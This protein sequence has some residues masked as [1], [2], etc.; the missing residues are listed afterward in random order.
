MGN[1]R[2]ITELHRVLTGE[3]N[4]D[5][6]DLNEYLEEKGHSDQ[7]IEM[8]G[9]FLGGFSADEFAEILIKH[10]VELQNKL[11]VVKQKT[12]DEAV[13]RELNRQRNA[14]QRKYSELLTL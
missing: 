8:I 9:P 1:K 6:M 3:L 12:D 2:T 10:Q 7:T 13:V 11:N 14:L 5:L 4:E